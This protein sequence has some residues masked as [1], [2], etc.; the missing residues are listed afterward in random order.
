MVN[1]MNSGH[2]KMAKWG[3][4]HLPKED[5]LHVLDIGCG[6]GANVARLLKKY[7]NAHVTGVDY[8]E[9]SV[10]KSRVFNAEAIRAGRCLIQQDNVR[11]LSLQ[12]HTYDLV[13]AFETIYFWPEIVE[14]F[15]QVRRVLK[16]GGTFFI[17]NECDGENP[18]DQKWENTIEGMKIYKEDELVAYLKEAGFTNVKVDHEKHLIC[19]QA[20]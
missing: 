7:N 16:E 6:G 17:C 15:K 5:Y 1:M 18:A 2:S 19:F 3:M 20:K 9:V 8:S 14:S 11:E 13:T 12:D 4:N 10:E